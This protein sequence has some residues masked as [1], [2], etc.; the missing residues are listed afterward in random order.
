MFM[1]LRSGATYLLCGIEA[2]RGHAGTH[3]ST[4]LFHFSTHKQARLTSHWI[5]F[6]DSLLNQNGSVERDEDYLSLLALVYLPFSSSFYHSKVGSTGHTTTAIYRT[7][8]IPQSSGLPNFHLAKHS[9][10]N[11]Y[12]LSR[13]MVVHIPA[14][15]AIKAGVALCAKKAAVGGNHAAATSTSATVLTWILAHNIL[16]LTITEGAVIAET[17]MPKLAVLLEKVVEGGVVR[18]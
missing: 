11:H 1:A 16:V 4:P 13:T 6:L 7:I 3:S 10:T 17:L 2:P 18:L 12:K 14:V 9:T 15:V 5:H 8:K